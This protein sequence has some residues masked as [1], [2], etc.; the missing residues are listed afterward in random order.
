[1]KKISIMILVFVVALASCKKTPE[2]NLKYVDVERDLITVGTATATVQCDYQYIA[3]LKKAY[4]YYGEGEDETDMN[5]AEMRVVQNT[6]YIDLAGLKENTTYSYY[7]EFHNGFNAMRTTTKTFETEEPSAIG[8]FPTVVT[9]PVRVISTT[10][11]NSGGEVTDDGGSE[12]IERGICWSK[13]GNPTLEDSHIS[14]GSGLGIFIAMMRELDSCTYYYVRSY[15]TNSRGTAYGLEK[16]FNTLESI[17]EE[18][19]IGAI[20]GLFSISSDKQVYFSQGNLQYQ[21]TTNTWQFAENQWDFIGEANSNISPT[22]NGWIDLFGWGT[23]GWDNGNVYYQPYDWQHIDDYEQGYGYGPTDGSYYCFDLTGEYAEAD[24]GVHNPI[25]NGGNLPGLWRTLSFKE[26]A[27]MLHSR[28]TET[29]IRFVK[30]MVNGVPGAIFF[31]DNWNQY[32]CELNNVNDY[33]SYFDCNIISDTLWRESFEANGAV[34]LPAAGRRE[35]LSVGSWY[36][37]YASSSNYS[38]PNQTYYYHLKYTWFLA[39]NGYEVATNTMDFKYLGYSV[40]LVHD[41]P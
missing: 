24:W 21:A 38:I 25:S 33:D 17:S 41:K 11:A 19:P 28:Q 3:T 22:Y 9:S 8:T 7:Y 1:M 18:P 27:Y 10:S 14:V 20:N 30:A 2:V 35:G 26:W 32:V 40:R 5:K 31:P 6:L 29:G 4:L 13:F 23:S 34:F 36:G 39:I 16:K 37:A 15:A 12:I